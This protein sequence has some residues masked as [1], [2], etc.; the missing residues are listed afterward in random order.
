MTSAK[1]EEAALPGHQHG[2]RGQ[3]VQVDDQLHDDVGPRERR[4]GE[5]RIARR[6]RAHRVEQVRDR[7]HAAVEGELGLGGGGVRVAGRHRHAARD[8]LVDELERTRQLGR[9]RDLGDRPRVEQPAQQREVGGR[10]PARVVR[11]GAPRREERAFEVRAEH[12][13]ADVVRRQLPQRR[14]QRFLGCGDERRLEGRRA[15]REQRLPH[16]QVARPVGRHQVH[17]GEAVDLQ[18]DETGRRDPAPGAA[19][20][21]DAADQAIVDLHVP[22]QQTARRPTPPARPVAP[23]HRTAMTQFRPVR[24]DIPAHAPVLDRHSARAARRCRAR[25]DRRPCR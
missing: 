21:P 11:A 14:D 13:R 3:V 7:A 6:A 25:R 16:A 20:E 18:V 12:A 17:A 4:P 9:Q 1:R 15:R 10:E 23:A 5:A 8:E 22:G 19:G 2:V 24:A